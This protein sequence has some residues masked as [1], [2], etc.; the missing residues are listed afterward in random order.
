[1][2]DILLMYNAFVK[3]AFGVVQYVIISKIMQRAELKFFIIIINLVKFRIPLANHM[4]YTNFLLYS[5][6]INPIVNFFF[7]YN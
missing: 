5:L 1:M 4:G 2:T 6:S 7:K 3:Y